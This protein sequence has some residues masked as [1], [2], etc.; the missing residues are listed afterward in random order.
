[1]NKYG[2]KKV[3][4]DGEVFDSRKEARRYREL[5]LLQKAGKISNLQRQEE[6]VLI[7]NQYATEERYSKSGKRLKDK[8]I[9][10]ERKVS[11]IAD[12]TYLDKDYNLIVEDVKSEATKTAEF[13]IKKKMMLY[14]HGIRVKIVED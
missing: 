3:T 11:Y 2:N 12:F 4:V 6:F 1:M 7:P 14:I 9:L 5:L 13:I 10:L 8:Q